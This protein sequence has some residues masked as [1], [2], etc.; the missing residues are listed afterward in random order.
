MPGVLSTDQELHSGYIKHITKTPRSSLR[1]T[2]IF[3]IPEESLKT[4]Y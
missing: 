2:K 3:L 1:D 4:E